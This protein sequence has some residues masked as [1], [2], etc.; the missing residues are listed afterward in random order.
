MQT[1]IGEQIK[2]IDNST[3]LGKKKVEKLLSEGFKH[4]GY[5]ESEQPTQRLLRGFNQELSNKLE[6]K[7][8]RLHDIRQILDR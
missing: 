2:I 7:Y 8:T 1:D 6:E 3:N 4:I 5:L